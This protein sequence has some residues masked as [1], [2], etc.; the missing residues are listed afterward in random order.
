M[1]GGG[2]VPCTQIDSIMGDLSVILDPV[3]LDLKLETRQYGIIQMVR[4]RNKLDTGGTA[5]I[6]RF[7]FRFTASS[8]AAC[9]ALELIARVMD[10]D[11]HSQ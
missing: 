1:G 7:K 6:A 8:L 9:F 2:G 10:H 5:Y 3:D 4:G 11:I